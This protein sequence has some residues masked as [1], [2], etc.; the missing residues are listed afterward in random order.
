VA[1][2]RLDPEPSGAVLPA[3]DVTLKLAWTRARK[4]GTFRI[5]VLTR[6]A[7]LSKLPF[8]RDK[9]PFRNGQ[10]SEVTHANLL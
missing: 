2:S 6:C 10:G 4:A 5:K 9:P 8:E 7:S 3:Y 1:P